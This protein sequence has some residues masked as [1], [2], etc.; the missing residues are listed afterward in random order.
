MVRADAQ[1]AARA[2]LAQVRT[3]VPKHRD[4][5]VEALRNLRVARRSAITG[6]ATAQRRIKAL[7]VTAPEQVRAQLRGLSTGELIAVC[8]ALRP[9]RG[10]CDDPAV[11]VKTTLRRLASRAVRR[12]TV[13]GGLFWQDR[14]APP[15][16][17]RGRR[18]QPRAVANRDH[19]HGH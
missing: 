18:R 2:A 14:P 10:R 8:A 7:V 17:R 1:A 13:T 19:P 6:R 9:D 11:A 12:G 4:G 15:Q 5:R 16:P 3:G